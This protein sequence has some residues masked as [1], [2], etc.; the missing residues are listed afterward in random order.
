MK[1]GIDT[2]FL[3]QVEIAEHPEHK[4]AYSFLRR[5]LDS[6]DGF[7]LAPQV[8]NEYIHIVTDKKRFERPLSMKEAL[9]RAHAWW[10]GAEI[11][12]I[13]PTDHSVSR[14]LTWMGRYELGRKRI[15]DTMLA[16]TY[17]AGGVR[18]I[19]TSNPGDFQ[20]F[21]EI[22]VI[23]PAGPSAPTGF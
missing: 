5:I 8:L 21:E 17:F 15:L 11:E 2:T 16:A 20:V 22:D 1:I 10:N 13:L 7:A 6:S 23:T 9:Y 19:V 3:I 18:T 4:R 12:Q 14:F